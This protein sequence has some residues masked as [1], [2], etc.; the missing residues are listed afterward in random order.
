MMEVSAFI[1]VAE[2][3]L[4]IIEPNISKNTYSIYRGYIKNYMLPY[5]YGK[6]VKEVND[7]TDEYIEKIENNERDELVKKF[8]PVF[9]MILDYA[10]EQG[11]ICFNY[12][13]VNAPFS[14][15][16]GLSYSDIGIDELAAI[17]SQA[18]HDDML[19]DFVL[20]LDLGLSRGEILG[21]KWGDV[22]FNNKT[23]TINRL[24]VARNGAT[25]IADSENKRTISL[26]DITAKLLVECKGNSGDDEFIIPSPSDATSPFNPSA[27]RKKIA[28]VTSKALDGDS[29]TIELI[30]LIL[31]IISD[32]ASS[33][34]IVSRETVFETALEKSQNHAAVEL[35]YRKAGTGYVSQI[36]PNCWQGRYTPTINGKR[37]SKNVYAATKEECEKK[38]SEMIKSVKEKNI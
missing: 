31:S 25:C 8:Y 22:D 2:N 10:V 15:D 37:I 29:V 26:M 27:Y 14:K 20:I 12:A 11:Y 17:L 18:K 23:L 35:K 33:E 9:S 1:T 24:V 28:K 4:K 3:W 21:L 36:S 16:E 38:L 13:K 6:S 19:L 5:F 30:G 32:Q 34:E 7:N